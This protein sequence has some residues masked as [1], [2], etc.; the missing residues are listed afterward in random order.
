P[1]AGDVVIIQPIAG[2]PHGHMAMFNGTLWVSDFKQL[3][4]FYPGH[5]Y[6]VHKPAYKIYRHP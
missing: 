6:R 3:H 5:S 1:A 4:G 2:H